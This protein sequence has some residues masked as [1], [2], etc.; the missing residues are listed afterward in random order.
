MCVHMITCASVVYRAPSAVFSRAGSKG[1]LALGV[2][3]PRPLGPC[4]LGQTQAR[5]ASAQGPSYG[6]RWGIIRDCQKV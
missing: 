6:A 1:Q 2:S 3:I 4:Q 5:Q